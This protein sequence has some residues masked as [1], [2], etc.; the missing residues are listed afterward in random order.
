M[1]R[2]FLAILLAV[3]TALVAARTREA[4]SEETAAMAARWD[5]SGYNVLELKRSGGTATAGSARIRELESYFYSCTPTAKTPC[6]GLLRGKD[7]ILLLAENWTAPDP[8]PE[9]TPALWRM[10]AEGVRFQSVY[11]PDW[12]QGM[13]GREFALLTGLAPT[14]VQESTS[15]AW[16]GQQGTYLPF[17]LGVGLGAAGYD[18]RAYT[19]DA[20][21][22][23]YQALGF[24]VQQRP[25]SE[26]DALAQAL[27]APETGRPWAAYFVLSGQDVEQTLAQLWQLLEQT[28]RQD[29][30]AVCLAAA[31]DGAGRGAL[32]LRAPGLAGTEVAAPCSELDVTPTLLDL[33]GAPYD[34]RFLSGRD[35]L[36]DGPEVDVPVSLAGSAYCDWVTAAGRYHAVEGVFSPTDGRFSG[37]SEARR[38]VGRMRQVVYDRYSYARQLLECNYFQLAMGR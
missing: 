18:C 7:L 12:F 9:Q 28:G 20:R 15:L 1:R 13:D 2:V 35:V 37:Q 11:A 22:E 10:L 30:T 8:T 29:S 27:S 17:S 36:A 21:P 4:P 5:E 3:L 33:F 31:G 32:F 14:A 34:A 23:A 16:V 24:A 25:A 6:T 26:G 38:Y 19:G